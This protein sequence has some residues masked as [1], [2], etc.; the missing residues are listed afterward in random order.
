MSPRENL[1]AETREWLERSRG[2]LQAC[3]ALIEAGLPAEALFH[4]QQCAEKGDESRS[5]L[6]PGFFQE[7]A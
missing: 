4:A 1:V 6:A 3:D 2:D 5:H 7:D